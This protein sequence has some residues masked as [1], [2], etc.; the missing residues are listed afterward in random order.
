M[1]KGSGGDESKNKVTVGVVSKRNWLPPKRFLIVAV[2]SLIVAVGVI[3]LIVLLTMSGNKT[4]VAP[5]QT[6]SRDEFGRAPQ[7]PPTKEEIRKTHDVRRVDG[8]ISAV[9]PKTIE[10]TQSSGDKLVLNIESDTFYNDGDMM[11][12]AKRSDVKVGQKAV[13]SY[14]S[15][16]NKLS[17]VW[18]NYDK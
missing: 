9:T 14:D 13:V 4:G 7:A 3:V 1:A 15:E 5:S 17:S 6:V 12:P 8:V 18:V 2:G 16:G 10:L 11:Y